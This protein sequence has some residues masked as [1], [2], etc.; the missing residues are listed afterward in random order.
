LQPFFHYK[1][2]AVRATFTV[3]KGDAT[4]L[5]HHTCNVVAHLYP[6]GRGFSIFDFIWNDVIYS[7]TDLEWCILY[8]PYVM[9]LIETTTKTIFPKDCTH[10]RLCIMRKRDTGPQPP[11][12]NTRMAPG[13]PMSDTPTAAANIAHVAKAAATAA[14]A[15]MGHDLCYPSRPAY[16]RPSTSQRKPKNEVLWAFTS[17]I[18]LCRSNAIEINKCQRGIK[19]LQ[20]HAGLPHSPICDVPTFSGP[21]SDFEDEVTPAATATSSRPRR[22]STHTYATVE[23]SEEDDNDEETEDDNDEE[24]ED[25]DE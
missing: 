10:T 18:K 2:K 13:V 14:A 5:L 17:L 4:S 8:A 25:D 20:D 21:W 11:P 23:A 24:T 1:N 12:Q 3:K 9:F 7:G 15:A 16:D 6:R 19:E 22:S